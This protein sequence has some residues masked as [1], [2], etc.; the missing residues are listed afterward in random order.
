MP[1]QDQLRLIFLAELENA[2]FI[3]MR[4]KV[5]G[6]R[7]DRHDLVDTREVERVDDCGDIVANHGNDDRTTKRHLDGLR[8]ADRFPGDVANNTVQV[9]GNDEDSRHGQPFF[10]RMRLA[11]NFA[12]SAGVPVSISAFDCSGMYIR[13]TT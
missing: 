10:S 9:F 11:M 12:I 5:V 13:L 1:E 2:L 8:G 6:R 4:I 7:L 3:D